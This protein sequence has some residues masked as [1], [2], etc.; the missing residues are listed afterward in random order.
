MHHN[1]YIRRW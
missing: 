1:M